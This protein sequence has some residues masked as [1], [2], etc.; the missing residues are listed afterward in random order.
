MKP[1]PEGAPSFRAV[2]CAS[3]NNRTYHGHYANYTWLPYFDADE[4]CELY[5]SDSED[6]VIVP[7]GGAVADGTPCNVG[8]RDMCIGRVCRVSHGRGFDP[9]LLL[10]FFSL[11]EVFFYM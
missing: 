5:C 4:P 6:T 10:L 9:Q 2:Q 7:W 1:C 11:V 8:R 3:Y